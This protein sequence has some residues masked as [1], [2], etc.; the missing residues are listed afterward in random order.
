MVDQVL[1]VRL[2]VQVQHL[3]PVKEVLW[4]RMVQAQLHQ[5]YRRLLHHT[6][7]Q[8]PYLMHSL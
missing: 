6:R 1:K 2:E 3:T 8:L 4:D 5:V 7:D